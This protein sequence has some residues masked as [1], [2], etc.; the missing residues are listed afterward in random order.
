MS[1]IFRPRPSLG[2]FGKDRPRFA[3]F[4]TV[5]KIV[6]ESVVTFFPRNLISGYKVLVFVFSFLEP[7]N[8]GKLDSTR[9]SP[10]IATVATSMT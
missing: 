9:Y 1:V 3:I 6:S 4:P 2:E 5:A 8:V 7:A 10:Q